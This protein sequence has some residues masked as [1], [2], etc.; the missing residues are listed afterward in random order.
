MPDPQAGRTEELFAE[1]AETGSI[2][3]RNELV[4]Q[5]K[6]L[7]EYFANRYRANASANEDLGQVAQMALV[8][9]VDRFDHTQIGRAHV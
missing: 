4:E 5:F 3:V 8:K 6:P 1:L 7:A 9:S 2:E